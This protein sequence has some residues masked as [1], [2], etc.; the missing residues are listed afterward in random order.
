MRE[1]DIA[2]YRGCGNGLPPI[3]LV[4]TEETSPGCV[5]RLEHEYALKRELDADWAAR[6]V[7]LT[8]YD[9]RLTLVLED[10]GGV[11][12]DR[13]LGRPLECLQFL[14]IAIPLAGALRRMHERGVIH[15][16]IKPANILMDATGGGVWLTGFGIASRLPRERQAPAPPEV[17]AGT[18]AYMAPEQTGRMNRSV[19]YRSDLYALGVTLYEM[20]TGQLPFTAADPMEWV[21]CH[22]A[23]QPVPPN[24]RV[25]GIPDPLS[26]IV[27]KLLAKTA[28][29]RYQTA[30]GVE[31]DL[32]RCLTEWEAS[33]RIKPFP[34]GLRDHSDRLLIP[35][36]LYGREREI[37][38]LLA[39]F[40]RV[41]A[42]GATE[43]VL[44]SGY[45][46]IG[47]SAVVHEL[48][49]ALV[50]PR[51]LFAAGKFDQYKRDIPY[52]TLVQ[53]FQS[54]VRPLLGKSEARLAR[55][56]ETLLE[57]LGPNGRLMVDLVPELKLIIGDQPPVPELPPQDAQRR[58]QLVFRRFIG[59]FAR[60]EHPL[61][62]FLDD[63]QWLDAATLDLIEDL[64]TRSDLQHFMLIGAY[65]NNEVDALHPLRQRLDAVKNAGAKVA[66]ITLAPLAQEHLGQLIADALRCEPER[67]A[68]L[69]QLVREKTGGNPFFAIQFAS[70]LAE[71]GMLV[72]DHGA[73]RWS[74]DLDRIH[75]KGYTDNVVGLMVGKLTRLPADT[76]NALRLLACLGNSA[77]IARLSIVLDRSQEGVD[78]ALWPAVQQELV[79]RLGGA[80]R[81][82]HD[83]V[84]EAAY[85]LIPEQLRGE[86]HLQIGRRLAAHIPPE[87]REEAIFDIVSQLDRGVSL[88]TSGDER[89][90]LAQFNLLAGKRAKASTAYASAL[91]YLVTGATLLPED[92]WERRHKLAF[93]LELLR[94]ECEFVTGAMAAAEER[95]KGLSTHAANTVE[96][97]AVAC[98]HIDL[99]T[100]LAQSSRAIAVGLDYLRHLGIEWS[101]HPTDGDVRREYDRI[102]S[103]LGSRSI[104]D[105]LELPLMTDPASLATIDVLTK[106]APAALTLM[107]ANFHALAICWA[108][109][110]S[111]ERG[112]SDG[113]C[114]I[115]VRLGFIAGDRFGDYKAGSRF[116][117]VGCELLERRGLKRFQAR[118]YLL[119]AHYLIPY[120]QH[121]RAARDL[122]QRGFEVANKIG[123]LV[124]VALYGG[125]YLIE[126]L[127]ASGEPLSEVQ[128]EIERGLAFA[129]K[130]QLVNVVS[131]I[132]S[133]LELVRTLRGLTRKFGSFDEDEFG[134]ARLAGNPNAALADWLYW[135]RRVQAHFHAGDYASAIEASTRAQRHTPSG[136]ICQVADLRFY[137][138]LSHA[139]VCDT[140]SDQRDAHFA[141]LS[142]HHRQLGIWAEQCPENFENRAALVAAEIAR[143]EGRDLDAMRLYQQGIRSAR[144]NG[145]VQNEALAYELAARFYASRGFDEI[146][147]LYL[148][149]ARYGY[150]RWGADGKVRQ[151]DEIH[152]QLRKDELAPAPTSTIGTSVERLDVG[153]VLKAAQAV[154]GEIVLGEL[155]KT[156]LRIAI[157]HAG[158][159]RGLLILFPGDEPRV[160]AEATTGRGQIEVRLRQTDASPAELPESVLHTVIRTRQSVILDDASAHNPFPADEYILQKHARSVL[161][162]PLVK[163][164]KLIGVLYL[165]NNLA[166]H[167]FTSSRISVLELLA[168]QAAIS[169]ENARLYSDLH[170]REARI[171]RLVDSNIIGVVIWDVHGRIVDANQAFLDI[172]GHVREDL[173][174][175]RLRWTELTP[176]EWRDADEQAITE[177][178]AAGTLQPREKEY[179]RKDGSRVPVLV[180]R[181][182]F[183][184]KPDEGVSFVID[185]TDRKRAEEKLRASEQ[186]LLDAQME[187]ARV[188]RV[189]TLGELT[190]SIAHEVNQPLAAVVSAGTACLSWLNG[191]TPNLDEARSAVG[192]I[193]K[194]GNRAS[195]VIRRV[196][197]LANKTDIETAPLDVNDVVRESIALMR[198]ELI[199]YRVSL[200]ME[201]A[202]ALPRVLG[203]RVQLQQVIINLVMNGIEAMQSVTDRPRELVVRSGQDEAG[204][205]LV[206]VA[207]CGVGIAAEN[208]DRLFN[209]FF[210]TKSSGMGMGLSICR[211]IMEAHG[212]RLWAT[213]NAPRGA[214]FQFTLP[215]DAE[216]VS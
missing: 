54:L 30:A 163:Q 139:A 52:S 171:R 156:L 42:S 150:L 66:E 5:E 77:E 73:A 58:F 160:A 190:A 133:H 48:H 199:S 125:L 183:E 167:V 89:E 216:T 8:R 91:T 149:N 182:L 215:V 21:H 127:L 122:L 87:K 18:L 68:S 29:E 79:E 95:L 1:G 147:H 140:S 178:K 192:W 67:A 88:I 108:A 63:L 162:L 24:E 96:R 23:R 116:G 143:L 90:Q 153:T 110:L 117:K 179:L 209:A 198:R 101:P 154:S 97:A 94:A 173:V 61:A 152:P 75:A 76:Q 78:A 60:P 27:T 176:A 3:L 40:D 45:S 206:S 99:Y 193:I 19:D 175:G 134:D 135:M 103:Q 166:S 213:A 200:R 51:G 194:E 26:A 105:M 20:L 201:L 121:V 174:S 82:A 41:V 113:S 130:A 106:V 137:S 132:R 207:D 72:F 85:S 203:D 7:A 84:Q 195:E 6:P 39:S 14:R 159:E 157:E 53:A 168:S 205:A 177:L 46:G 104:E 148:R 111:L 47:K 210:T 115:Y 185:M 86:A 202:P 16:D 98:L 71:E 144:V 197:A 62:L 44:V 118:T 146:A 12:L 69:A 15:K 180:A 22:V 50:P 10:P 181:A 155:I 33:G 188:T 211:S 126:N 158:A 102:W 114:D 186:R 107:E 208:V 2:L 80:Y 38:A 35:E 59:V 138:A 109:N 131:I 161:C 17:I 4:A 119:F 129:Q 214:T 124:F 31:A 123:D 169:L 120:T 189:T 70:S 11:T 212:G 64:L 172:V 151:L 145:F 55:W 100:T 92:A 36:K 93:E 196:R 165:E 57:A 112:N 141:A 170:E 164:A 25:A 32:R 204:Q 81:F 184:S 43:L 34:P 13:L 187:L 83:R 9:D 136:Y 65:R 56:R 28:E 191:G 128:G 74:W 49:K 142:A 37:A